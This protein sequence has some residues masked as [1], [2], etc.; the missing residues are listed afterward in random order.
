MKRIY[1]LLAKHLKGNCFESELMNGDNVEGEHDETKEQMLEEG[2][3]DSS[4]EAFMR[5]YSE[6]E[7]VE[8][9]AECGAAIHEK[10]VAKV[11][12]EEPRTFCSDLCAKE[13][14]ESLGEQ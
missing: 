5:G 14:E 11:I 7:E 10:K 12:E 13:Y 4:E 1:T 3:I 8:E 6:D 2:E 9:C